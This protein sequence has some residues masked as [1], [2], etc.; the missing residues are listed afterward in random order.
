MPE[1]VSKKPSFT[2]T[3]ILPD[4]PWLMPRRFMSW[5]ALAMALR[6]DSYF[7]IQLQ[8]WRSCHVLV[9]DQDLDRQ[10]GECVGDLGV[11]PFVGDEVRRLL[12][13]ADPDRGEAA[14]LAVIRDHGAGARGQQH[15]T[16]QLAL[17]ARV[18]HQPAGR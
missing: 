13:I 17:F 15:A 2:R 11:R 7:T 4:V 16:V 10:R 8:C 12:E 3:L 6:S 9:G 5:H 14:E 18:V 1:G